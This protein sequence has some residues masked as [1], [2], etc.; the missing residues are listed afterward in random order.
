MFDHTWGLKISSTLQLFAFHD[1]N[2][3]Y[4]TVK[5]P[6]HC[7]STPRDIVSIFEMSC[8]QT[9]KIVMMEAVV[10]DNKDQMPF[11][12]TPLCLCYA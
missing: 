1:V 2:L 7:H 6:D 4:I 5:C 3:L 8:D 10:E 12:S 9:M 11:C